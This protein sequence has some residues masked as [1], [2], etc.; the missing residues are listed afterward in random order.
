MEVF[1]VTQLADYVRSTLER[2]AQLRDIWV[3]G[4]VTNLFESGA[5]HVYF[6]VKD[7]NSQMRSVLFVGNAGAQHLVG[8]AQV[9]VH[10]RVSF[11]PVRGETQLYV[12]I[13]VPAGLGEL[14]AE[15]ERMR[16]KLEAEGLFDTSR[17]RPLPPFPTTIGV[18]TSERGAVIHDITQTLANRYPLVDVILYP[19]TVQGDSAP[20]EIAGGIRALNAIDGV[21]VIIVGRGGGSMEDLWAFNTEEVARAIYS[22]HVPIVSAVGHES[23]FTIADFVADLRAP[24]PT[25]AAVLTTPD[26]R[27]LRRQV[28]T[29]TR[30]AHASMSRLLTQR[31]RTVESL[32][33]RMR[34]TLPDTPTQRQ[35]VDD[36]LERG[37]TALRTLFATRREQ[38]TGLTAALNALNPTAVIDR[39][40]AVLTKSATGVTIASVDDV[41]VGDIVRARVRDGSF[42]TTVQADQHGN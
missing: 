30:H 37:R 33:V 29:Q 24:T 26:V 3:T 42:E 19:A 34:N 21:S 1:T 25:G 39:G 40:F 6:A 18:V 14:A 27:D 28:L 17:K 13:V 7:A 16:A 22:S 10:G 35:R 12:D 15:F 5:G 36:V 31:S 23:D 2:D 41:A 32:V 20:A 4:E 38:T 8:G 9:N 11:Y